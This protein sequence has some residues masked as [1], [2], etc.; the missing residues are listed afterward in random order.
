MLIRLYTEFE[1]VLRR[2][3]MRELVVRSLECLYGCRLSSRTLSLL[4]ILGFRKNASKLWSQESNSERRT[5]TLFSTWL[6]VDCREIV[7]N[8]L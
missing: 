2:P 7:P 4:F 3:H 5:E 6:K 1:N 8:A